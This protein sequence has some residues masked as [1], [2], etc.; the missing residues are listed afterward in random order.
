M[1]RS[2]LY[3][4]FGRFRTTLRGG[5]IAVFCLLFFGS[6]EKHP[7]SLP[8]WGFYRPASWRTKRS[9]FTRSITDG[10][11]HVWMGM[12]RLKKKTNKRQRKWP[13]LSTRWNIFPTESRLLRAKNTTHY[14]HDFTFFF[15]S[16]VNT[17]NILSSV[18]RRFPSSFSKPARLQL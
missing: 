7:F 9:M 8:W 16:N 4:Y 11:V 15:R 2:L 6:N 5:L 18:A 1:F 14:G 17:G 3:H 12:G 13:N 10:G